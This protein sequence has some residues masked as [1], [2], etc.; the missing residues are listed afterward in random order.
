MILTDYFLSTPD[1]QWRLA[2][3]AGVQH[4]VVRLPEEEAF[5][6]PDPARLPSDLRQK[7]FARL[8][9][10]RCPTASTTTSSAQMLCAMLQLKRS[11]K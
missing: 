6:M 7:G 10:S 5:D 4:A 8:S 9:S 1:L 3:Q 2:K 11:F